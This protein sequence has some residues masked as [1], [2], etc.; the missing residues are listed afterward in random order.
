MKKRTTRRRRKR[1]RR[2]DYDVA[3]FRRLNSSESSWCI[4]SLK[5]QS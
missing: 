1:G 4:H 3:V 2:D 5:I